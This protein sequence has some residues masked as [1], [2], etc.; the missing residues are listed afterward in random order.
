MEDDYLIIDTR[1]IDDFKKT[2]FSGYKKKDVFTIL[3][4]SI[5]TKK[6]ENACN[7]LTECLCSGYI[8]ETWQ[9][10]ICFSCNIITINNP[11]LPNYLYKKNILLY[12]IINNIDKKKINETINL[13]NNQIIRNLFFSVRLLLFKFLC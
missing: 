12:N 2:T 7:W 1:I 11:L 13:R 9:K 10:L 6:I 5:E 8:E 3:F 4:K